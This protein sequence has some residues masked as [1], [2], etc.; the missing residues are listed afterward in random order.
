MRYN[1]HLSSTFTIFTMIM[2]TITGI[3]E[4]VLDVIFK[5]DQ[6]MAAVPGGSTFNAMISIGRTVGRQFPQVG[7]RMVSEVGDDHIADIITNFMEQNG[8]SSSAVTRRPASQSHVSMAFLDKDN[9]ADYEFYKD[10]SHAELNP[11]ALKGITFKP[12]DIVLFGSYFAVNPVIRPFTSRLLNQA[13]EAGAVIYYDINFRKPHISELKQILPSIQENCRLSDFVRGSD[14]DFGYLFGTQDPVIIYKDFISPLCRNFICTCGAEPV[15]V[16]TGESHMV[17][18]VERTETVS[19]IGAGDSFNA[20]FI[21]SLFSKG[22][23]RADISRLDGETWAALIGTAG[24]FSAEVCRSIFNY[25]AV[26]P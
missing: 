20:G 22:I 12:D 15:H 23:T 6:P 1:T 2:R 5:D 25:V 17:F 11:V 16:F 26:T 14:E 7:I 24:K 8:V 3:G 13:R 10:H 9:N 21:Y 4:T 18:P 19:T